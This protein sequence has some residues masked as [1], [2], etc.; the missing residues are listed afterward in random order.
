MAGATR[1][2]PWAVDQLT[3]GKPGPPSGQGT[4]CALLATITKPCRLARMKI[5]VVEVLRIRAAP[6]NCPRVRGSL[7]PSILPP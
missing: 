2:S 3:N 5:E 6:G 4:V 1:R 7:T